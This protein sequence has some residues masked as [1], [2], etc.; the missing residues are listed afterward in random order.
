MEGIKFCQ[1]PRLGKVEVCGRP[2]IYDYCRIHRN[3]LRKGSKGPIVCR[4]CGIGVK[5]KI[6]LCMSCGHDRIAHRVRYT[7]Q[8][9]FLRL[10][11]INV[12]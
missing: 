2:C 5:S 3:C 8:N 10:A 11:A 7:I 9:E 1:W 4:G 6:G 12:S